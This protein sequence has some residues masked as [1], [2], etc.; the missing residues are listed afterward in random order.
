MFTNDTFI[1]VTLSDLTEEDSGLYT[2]IAIGAYSDHS[3]SI[4]L[5][6][7]SMYMYTLRY[8]HLCNCGEC[9]GPPYITAIKSDYITACGS[10]VTLV[11]RIVKPGEPRASFGWT[12]NGNGIDSTHSVTINESYISIT[13]TN[14]TT[15]DTGTYA[16]TATGIESYHVDSIWL[17]VI[18]KNEGTVATYACIHLFSLQNYS[19][20]LILYYIATLAMYNCTYVYYAVSYHAIRD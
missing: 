10:K 3:D 17:H 7:E 12:K 15:Q 11:C 6:V 13:L 20:L 9:I 4:E 1:S 5:I 16:C 14:V 19:H 2:C 18:S 8:F